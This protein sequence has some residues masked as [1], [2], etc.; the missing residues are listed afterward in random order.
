MTVSIGSDH[1]GYQL[2]EK[3]IKALQEQGYEIIDQ[4]CQS[5]ESVDYP[6]YAR[7]VARDIQTAVSEKGILIC[8][9]GIGM[10]IVANKFRGI[11]AALVTNEDVAALS[12]Q[13]NDSNIICL[14][15]KYTPFTEAIKYIL[16]FL[17]AEFLGER[18]SRRVDMI[19][20]AKEK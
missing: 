11:R 6:F 14:G 18:H 7:R 15:A 10:S 1:G 16:I 5:L 8:T 17:E 3:L 13:H 9:T 20:E 12:R 4:G 19:E 2:K